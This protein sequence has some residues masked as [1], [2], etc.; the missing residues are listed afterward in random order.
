MWLFITVVVSHHCCVGSKLMWLIIA[1]VVSHHGCD[2]S[3]LTWLFVTVVVSDRC[4]AGSICVSDFVVSFHHN[5]STITVLRTGSSCSGY[6]WP[7]GLELWLLC[8]CS[9]APLVIGV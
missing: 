6:L 4:C 7:V 5:Y 3:K 2:G 8:F 1:V 9:L